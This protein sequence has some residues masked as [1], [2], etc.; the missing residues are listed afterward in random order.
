M[1]TKDSEGPSISIDW[2]TVEEII[3]RA[4]RA[5]RTEELR[6]IAEA[7]K[8]IAE[9]IKKIY[10][11]LGRHAEILEG[12]SRILQEHSRILQEHSKILQ[13]HSKILEGHSKILESH[14][15]ILQEHS[16]ALMRIEASLRSLSGR[17]GI[18]LER[19][20]LNVYSD[21]LEEL[22]ISPARVEKISYKDIDGRYYRKG[23]RLEIDIYVHDN[24]TYFIEVKSL[25]ELDDVE[26]F[27]ERCEIF[28]KILGKKPVKKIIVAIN[29]MKEAIERA[30]ELGIETI[31]GRELEIK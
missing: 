12:H 1:S 15:K 7:I 18:D 9:H 14:S 28:E 21:I 4:V 17:V 22:G 23:A 19:M 10:E 27:Y 3:E 29:A 13:E 6:D 25:L 26:W 2:K 16:K 30:K 31:Y 11:I 8:T 5:A 24:I 20:I